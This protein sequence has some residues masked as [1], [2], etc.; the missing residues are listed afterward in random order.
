MTILIPMESCSWII[1]WCAIK[2]ARTSGKVIT[3]ESLVVVVMVVLMASQKSKGK[4]G[5]GFCQGVG[6]SFAAFQSDLSWIGHLSVTFHP[7]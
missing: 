3:R 6:G 7:S 5:F 4:R 2:V 1:Q